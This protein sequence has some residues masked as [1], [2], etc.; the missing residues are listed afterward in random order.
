[1]IVYEACMTDCSSVYR[2]WTVSDRETVKPAVSTSVGKG[3]NKQ[4][5]V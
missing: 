4:T 5:R 1:M 3:M 2:E